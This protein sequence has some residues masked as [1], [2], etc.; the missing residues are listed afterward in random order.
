MRRRRAFL[1]LMQLVLPGGV[2]AYTLFRASVGSAP[3]DWLLLTAA[4]SFLWAVAAVWVLVAARAA[5]PVLVRVGFSLWATALSWLL[6]MAILSLAHVKVDVAM[7]VWR[8]KQALSGHRLNGKEIG[9]FAAHPRY[10]WWHLPGAVGTHEF[11][12]YTVVY[13]TGEDR[14]RVTRTPQKSAG[15]VLCLGCS[16]TF[17][18]GVS[19]DEPYVAVLADR[20]WTDMK[21]HNAAVNGWGTTQALLFVEDYFSG[22]P[23]PAVVTYGWISK[24]L[25]RNSLRRHWLDS[26]AEYGRQN[27]CFEIANDRLVW[28]GLHGPEDGLPD[29]PGLDAAELDLTVRMLSAIDQVCRAHGSR[30]VVVLLPYGKKDTPYARQLD[31]LTDEVAMR[32]RRAGMESLDVRRSLTGQVRERLYFAHDPHPK[33]RWHQ[34]IAQAIAAAI[35]PHGRTVSMQRVASKSDE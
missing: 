5:W 3:G 6:G 14:F 12:D 18:H 7:T 29:S 4:G 28:S 27:P 30:F 1:W 2:L 19:D 33:P 34:L 31:S 23:A 22:H 15:E 20:Y 10:G 9:L 21:I 16:F 13:R 8:A 25:E 11:V 32:I 26:L 35:D 24:H 17:G